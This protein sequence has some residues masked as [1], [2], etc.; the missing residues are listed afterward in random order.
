[1]NRTFKV[2]GILWLAVL[3]L[4]MLGACGE[5]AA[6]TAEPTAAAKKLRV[7]LVLPGSISDQSFNAAAYEG[8]MAIKNEL[9]AE[10]AYS[11]AVPVAEFDETYRSYSE[12]GYDVIIGHGIEFGEPAAKI[13]PEF[14]NIYYLV[15][16][17]TVSG[18]NVAS[19]EPLFEQAAYLAGAVA[20]YSTK[21][22]K[23]GAVGGM[24][25]PIIVR[26]I[27]A[28]AAGAKAVNPNVEAT[29][30]YIGTLDDIA[31][32]K[33]AA[34]ALISTDV[35]VVFHIADAA[36]VG[37]IQACQE[38]G[39]YAIGFGAD[40]NSLAPE[41]VLTTFSVSYSALMVGAVR[42]IEEGK[43][44]GEVQQYGLA[45]GAVSLAPY[46]GLV[47]DDIAAKIDQMRQDIIDGKIEVPRIDVPPQ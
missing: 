9:G 45:D 37:V 7:A 2:L 8:L 10:V 36:G 23:V 24:T 42:R 30:T 3:L 15:T 5:Q 32:G 21:T 34:L 1:M 20:G 4:G 46:H 14:P 13:A 17:G 19:L 31:K 26:G 16:N 33:E 12:Q 28:F 22:N 38:K 44:V 27:E 6:P 11:E 47:P 29:T 35:D 43:F 18:P 39:V 40:Q 25:F 41:T